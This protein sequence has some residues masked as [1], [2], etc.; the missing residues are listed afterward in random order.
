MLRPL[1]RYV[2]TCPDMP[3]TSPRLRVPERGRLRACHLCRRAEQSYAGRITRHVRYHGTQHPAELGEAEVV[4]YVRELA[5]QQRVSRSTQMRV[6]SPLL[7]LCRGLFAAQIGDVRR[8]L[9]SHAP[10]RLPTALSRAEVR[11]VLGRVPG[12]NGIDRA[13]AVRRRASPVRMA[14]DAGQCSRFHA[15]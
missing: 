4:A 15:R 7:L 6:L 1:Q 13:P 2:H 8:V 3:D 14:D 11:A 9:R 10:T 5:S 12:T